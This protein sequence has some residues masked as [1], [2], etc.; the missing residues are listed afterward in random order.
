MLIVLLEHTNDFKIIHKNIY[1]LYKNHINYP[2]YQDAH[3]LYE[4]NNY[5]ELSGY[6]FIKGKYNISNKIFV[7]REFESVDKDTFIGDLKN[8]MIR[9]LALS[10]NSYIITRAMLFGDKSGFSKETKRGFSVS[11]TMHLFAV[12][13]FHVGCIFLF[14]CSLDLLST[15]SHQKLSHYLP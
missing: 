11:G 8:K 14:L 1:K 15:I 2:K 12:S 4:D 10:E 9:N 7:I 6:Y 13:G 3:F 5:N